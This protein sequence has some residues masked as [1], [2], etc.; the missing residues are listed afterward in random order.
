MS[1]RAPIVAVVFAALVCAVPALAKDKEKEKDRDR[2]EERARADEFFQT[3]AVH[4]VHLHVTYEQFQLMQPTRRARPAPLLADTI[5]APTEGQPAK[6]PAGAEEPIHAKAAPAEGQA[7]GVANYGFEFPYVK[8]RAEIDGLTMSDVGLRYKG[9]SSYDG[10]ARGLKRPMKLDFNRFVPGRKFYGLEAV[11]LGNNAFDPSLLRET[12]SYHVYRAAGVAAP[13]T[14]LAMVYLSVAGQCE[15]EYIGLYT[16]VEETDDDEFLKRH[17]GK[18]DLPVIKPER[19]R[20]LPYMGEEI[21]NYAERYRPK[22][23]TTTAD[24]RPL[25]EFVKLLN[26]A[27][28]A[29]FKAKVE[30]V[31]DVDAFLRYLACTALLG[32][33]DSILA[34]YHNFYLVIA[35]G[36][37]GEGGKVHFLPWDMNLSLARYGGGADPLLNLDIR[38]PRGGENQLSERILALAAYRDASLGHVR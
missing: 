3:T 1:T 17:F 35:P 38:H 24:A 6:P 37:K 14:T 15:H 28:D 36:A 26:Y 11:N 4:S 27:D 9:N 8:A 23:K 13:R 19:I 21:A 5:P 34:N 7:P 2:R 32:D 10:T 33:L 22:N 29:T 25:I 30:G 18:G 31:F 12:F 16:V 20:G